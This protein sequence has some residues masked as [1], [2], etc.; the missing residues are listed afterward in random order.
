MPTITDAFLELRRDKGGG[1]V[2]IQLQSPRESLLGEGTCLCQ[3][4]YCDVLSK[5]LRQIEVP[6]GAG[7]CPALSVR[8]TFV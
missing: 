1:F 6:D 2:D 8:Y 5:L 3:T 7:A 4:K